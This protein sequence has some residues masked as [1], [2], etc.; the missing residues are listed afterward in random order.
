MIPEARGWAL[1]T[2][3]PLWALRLVTCRGGAVGTQPA[4]LPPSVW[5]AGLAASAQHHI[6]VQLLFS[7]NRVVW[8]G[9]SLS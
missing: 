4:S 8:M 7:G 6:L 9:I 3:W 2:L 5:T 1:L